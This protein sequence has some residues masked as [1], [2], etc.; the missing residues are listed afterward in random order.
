MFRQVPEVAE[1][2]RRLVVGLHEQVKRALPAGA[3]P[4]AAWTV[5]STLLGAV[6]LA[7]ALVGSDPATAV[8]VLADAKRNLLARYDV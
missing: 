5:A 3:A 2:S 8:A 7:R 1:P 6:Q 4:D